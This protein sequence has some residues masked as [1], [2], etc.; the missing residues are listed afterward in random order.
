MIVKIL[1]FYIIVPSIYYLPFGFR[2]I[3]K[4]TWCEVRG[5]DS[6][7]LIWL[8]SWPSIIYLKTY[9]FPIDVYYDIFINMCIYCGMFLISLFCSMHL[10]FYREFHIVLI[11]LALISLDI[12]EYKLPILFFYF[13]KECYFGYFWPLTFP[14]ES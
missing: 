5:K 6:S 14:N 13:K 3:I 2:S 8:Y 4:M 1:F 11:L 7:F 9:S 10:S 12:W